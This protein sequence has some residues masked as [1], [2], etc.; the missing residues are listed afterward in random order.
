MKI[1]HTA[2]IHLRE[3]QDERWETLQELIEIGKRNGISIFAICGDLFD[4]DADAEKLRPQIRGVFS[5]A[6]FKILIIPGNH[7]IDSY[8][9][10]MYF[11][12]NVSVL[13]TLPYEYGNVRIVG[14][15]FEPIQ[16]EELLKKIRALREKL[17]SDKKNILLCH[18]EL[19]DAFFSRADFGPEGEG[20]Y[21]PFKLS[22]FEGLDIEYVLA[23]HFHSKF[24]VWR[25][26]NGGYFVYPGS[27]V[28]ITKAE[29]GQ[30]RVNLFE[31]GAPPSQVPLD[32][33]HFQEVSLE[34]DPL[35]DENPVEVV[36]EH[37][38]KLHS[39][40]TPILTVKG[41]VN[42]E[43]VK[44]TEA[45]IVAQIKEIAKGKCAEERYE[46]KD[47]STIL[48]N[49]LFKRFTNEA[50]ESGRTREDIKRLQDITIRAMMQAGL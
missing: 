19:L 11:G 4:K 6:A 32:T 21:M 7:D 28:S 50:T 42:S 8:K 29:T 39:K 44:M 45:D 27:P 36:Q 37:L 2:D 18:G 26:N 41:Y 17:T 14:I 48:E 20:R 31:V 9:T 38:R 30:R 33:F 35:K 15:P 13:G 22:Y 24:D 47:I 23:G 12:D 5:S 34:L 49:D 3:Y 10:G 25:L 1:L 43:Q 40:A 46:F 16:G